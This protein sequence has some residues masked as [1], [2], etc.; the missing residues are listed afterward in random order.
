MDE[1]KM[2][3]IRDEVLKGFFYIN[4]ITENGKIIGVFSLKQNTLF[5]D[6]YPNSL[7]LSKVALL[8]K[9]QRKGIGLKMIHTAVDIA[10]STK[11]SVLL[12]CWNMNEKLKTFYLK[13]GFNYIQD[14][15]ENDY[16]ISVFVQ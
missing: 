11:S 14:V 16:F 10:H 1:W 4:R 13:A 15:Q 8:P 6:K 2:L 3:D 12:D 5:I 7:Y 9:Y